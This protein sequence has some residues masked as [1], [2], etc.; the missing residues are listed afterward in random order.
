MLFNKVLHQNVFTMS[1]K[2]Q[3]VSRE[4]R[5]ITLHT[6]KNTSKTNLR[7]LI[8]KGDTAQPTIKSLPK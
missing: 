8:T 1:F 5:K 2:M 3:K 7:N 6:F 4:K